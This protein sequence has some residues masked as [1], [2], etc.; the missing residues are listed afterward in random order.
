M[1]TY[2]RIAEL[3]AALAPARQAAKSIG[4]VP[5]MGALHEGHLSLLSRAREE[6]DIVVMSLFVNPTQFNDP[7]DFEKY[8]RDIDRDLQMAAGVGC[9]IVFAPAREEIYP[10][11]FD[12]QISVPG[13]SDILEGASR[14][15]HFAGVA[16]VVAKL[17]NIVQPARAYFGEK[18]Y[19]QL[20]LVRR[21]TRDL[22]IAT[23]IVPCP[24]VRESDGLA[25]SSRNVRLSPADRKAATVLSRALSQAQDMANAGIRDA[26]ALAGAIARTI[27]AEPLA[28]LDYAV[29]VDRESLYNVERIDNSPIAL[30]AATF[31]PVR[32]IDNKTLTPVPKS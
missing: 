15:G 2:D 17:L 27:Q 3:R 30:V 29:I 13:L 5:T 14:P 20:Q 18:D 32:L 9:D 23:E 24:I 25:M 21:M 7:A 31:G 6:N 19:Q 1:H 22:D 10:D 11:G 12:T 4:F 28:K 26:R 16:T 8:P